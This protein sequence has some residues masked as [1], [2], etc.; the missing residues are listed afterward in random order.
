MTFT[1]TLNQP[2]PAQ[3]AVVKRFWD[4]LRAAGIT[5]PTCSSTP[6]INDGRTA[7]GLTPVMF[8]DRICF[9]PKAPIINFALLRQC[10][11]TFARLL[12]LEV[13]C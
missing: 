12:T 11:K 7:L 2:R 10:A 8:L 9:R 13:A 3:T 5:R 6:E 4:F 1:K